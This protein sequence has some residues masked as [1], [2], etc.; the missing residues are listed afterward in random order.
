ASEFVDA[1][2]DGSEVFFITGESLVEQD[3][4]LID[5][6]VAKVG[7]GF[8]PPPPPPAPCEGESC[9]AEA[10]PPAAPAPGSGSFVGPG[11]VKSEKPKPKPC[12][13]GFHKVKKGGKVRCVKNGKRQ[14]KGRR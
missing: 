8:P 3:P 1:S 14:G 13:K 9:Q 2:A 4:G 5:I 10:S 11:N 7:G 6:Y 12:R